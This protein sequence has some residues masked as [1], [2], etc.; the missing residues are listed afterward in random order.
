MAF[1]TNEELLLS[2]IAESTANSSKP[3]YVW[4][5]S[6]GNLEKPNPFRDFKK[7]S[8][9]K[10]SGSPIPATYD[11][12]VI[13]VETSTPTTRGINANSP[14]LL[15]P[16]ADELLVIL[17]D[18]DG[19]YGTALASVAAEIIDIKISSEYIGDS[20]GAIVRAVQKI[21]VVADLWI[22]E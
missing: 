17:G 14:T 4:I 5:D 15:P 20:L 8:A 13:S 2:N 6:N 21:I 3:F 12:V 11:R 22:A 18:I 16:I 19:A 9:F 1:Q 10:T 7:P